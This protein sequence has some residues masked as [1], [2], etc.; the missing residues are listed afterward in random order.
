MGRFSN[1]LRR[2]GFPAFLCTQFPGALN[3]NIYKTAV[4]PVAVGIAAG[5][6]GSLILSALLQHDS[7]I[8][9][10]NGILYGQYILDHA[11]VR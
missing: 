7:P 2:G 10:D 4:S 8:E 11:W 6:E 9:W 3:D 1:V 5:N